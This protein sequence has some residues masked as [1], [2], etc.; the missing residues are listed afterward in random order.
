MEIGQQGINDLKAVTGINEN[1]G[2]G[3]ARHHP[4]A[5]D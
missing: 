4:T 1:V 5:L 3:V 2:L